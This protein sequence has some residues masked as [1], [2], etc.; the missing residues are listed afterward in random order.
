MQLI[1][2]HNNKKTEEHKI[3]TNIKEFEVRL[4]D[5]PGDYEDGVYKTDV[6]LRIAEELGSDLILISDK[7]KPVICKIMDYSKFKYEKKN[8]RD[9]C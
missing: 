3:N 5:L 4:V 7:A 8:P 1:K 2:N 9:V 6:A